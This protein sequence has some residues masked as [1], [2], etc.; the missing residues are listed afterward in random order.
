M[1]AFFKKVARRLR[2][3]LTGEAPKKEDRFEIAARLAMEIKAALGAPLVYLDIGSGGSTDWNWQVMIER[4][5]LNVV[6]VDFASEWSKG[7]LP[8]RPNITKVRAALGD[9]EGSVPVY[10]THHPGCSSCL[11][12]DKEV[13]KSY[14]SC[15]W[16][17]VASVDTVDL[18]RYDV[19]QEIQDLPQPQIVKIDVQGYESQVLAG[20]GR[21]LDRVL[22]LEFECQL[23]A[24]YKGQ[25][26]FSE[27]Y[28]DL[29]TKGFV[30]RDLKPQGVF[31]G[32]ALE[33]N[34]FWA[35]LP[36]TPIEERII[37]FWALQNQIWTAPSFEKIDTEERSK[38]H[39][40]EVMR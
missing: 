5:L 32:E 20:L 18:Q 9:R 15:V 40:H 37:E 22:C 27:L 30:L 21:T 11:E 6:Q 33:F 25:R 14:P 19:L 34:S 1:I 35:R 26:V 8:D 36:Q 24:I 2:L 4:G 17:E 16:F 7:Q 28:D 39:F 12:P 31:E 3:L 38:Y 10:I 23:R 29:R 13:L